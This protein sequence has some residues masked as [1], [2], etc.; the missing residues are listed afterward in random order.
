[1]RARLFLSLSG[2]AFALASGTAWAQPGRRLGKFVLDRDATTK[3]SFHLSE[4][5]TR[6]YIAERA[7]GR[8][9]WRRSMVVLRDSKLPTGERVIE[10]ARPADGTPS[11]R[12]NLARL[13][14]STND[15]RAD[16]G[17]VVIKPYGGLEWTEAGKEP[18]FGKLQ[19]HLTGDKVR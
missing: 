16:Q 9:T 11:A 14:D 18:G 1:M 7:P 10:Y 2:I 8:R 17:S 5:R 6:L 3:V 15:F 4:G 13:S 19:V 12:F